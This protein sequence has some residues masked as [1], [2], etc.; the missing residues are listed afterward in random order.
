MK[1]TYA[2]LMAKVSSKFIPALQ[3][4][5]EVIPDNIPITYREHHKT[6]VLPLELLEK[7][8]Q[9]YD[10]VLSHLLHKVKISSKYTWVILSFYKK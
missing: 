6:K 9:Y 2:M 3:F 1:K 4:V 10:Q 7:N 8:E 5:E